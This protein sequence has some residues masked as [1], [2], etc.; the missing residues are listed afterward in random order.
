M[1]QS[2]CPSS[3][4]AVGNVFQMVGTPPFRGGSLTV[5]EVQRLVHQE[6]FNK[7]EQTNLSYLDKLSNMIAKLI[8]PP[9]YT[10]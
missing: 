8:G 10:K 9:R 1:V 6:H 2:T 7:S 5:S 3:N 4:S